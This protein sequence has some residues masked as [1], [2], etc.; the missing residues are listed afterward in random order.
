MVSCVH[1]LTFQGLRGRLCLVTRG[2]CGLKSKSWMFAW[3]GVCEGIVGLA[4]VFTLTFARY[5]VVTTDAKDKLI[6]AVASHISKMCSR[7][8]Q[9]GEAQVSD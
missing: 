5:V 9:E 7:C 4:A 8:Q 3:C 1:I 2:V 6:T